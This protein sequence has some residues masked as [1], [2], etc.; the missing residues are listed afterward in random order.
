M[1]TRRRAGAAGAAAAA[2]LVAGACAGP[3]PGTATITVLAAASLTDAFTTMGQRWEAAHPGTRV[4]FSFAGSSSLVEQVLAGAP[5]DVVATADEATMERLASRQL[6]ETPA[7]FATN[8]LAIVVASGNPSGITSVSDLG[9]PDLTLVLC[10]VEVPCGA[11]AAR[12]LDQAGV[13]AR[14]RSYEA[15]V[16]AVV[17]RVALGEADAGIV[18]A[19]DVRAGGARLAG[20][21]VPPGQNVTTS[22]LVAAVKAGRSRSGARSLI[23]FVLSEDGR[24]VLA[25]AGFGSP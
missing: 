23:S 16:K 3:A 4:V 6:V 25:G 24:R 11:L 20:V 21:D 22:Y 14:P 2:L 5:A 8:R 19:T 7:V 9:R 10:A 13:D 1:T 15:N 18:Y 12:M 17:S